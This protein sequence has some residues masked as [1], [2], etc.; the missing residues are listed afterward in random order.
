MID[1]FADKI[2]NKIVNLTSDKKITL[3][4]NENIFKCK[5]IDDKYHLEQY[6]I[7]YEQSELIKHL[8]I[9]LSYF[10]YVK[11]ILVNTTLWHFPLSDV[12][13]FIDQLEHCNEI[14]IQQVNDHNIN[15]TKQYN[16]YIYESTFI[17]NAN[18]SADENKNYN[19][20]RYI[21]GNIAEN[22]IIIYNS[23]YIRSCFKEIEQY[24]NVADICD[25]IMDYIL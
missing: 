19:I 20:L 24:I 21:T 7:F 17:L 14:N 11:Y 18:L 15:I 25:I 5:L 3:Y 16:R 1:E 12:A 2:F 23:F 4:K 9:T 13:E 8:K 22:M 6:I 10:N